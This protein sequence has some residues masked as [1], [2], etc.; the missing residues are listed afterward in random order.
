MVI[1]NIHHTADIAELTEEIA[2]KGHV[3]TGIHNIKHRTTKAPL[4]MFYVNL[5]PQEN[6]KSVYNIQ[7]LQ[8]MKVQVEPPYAKREIVQCLRCQRYGHTKSYCNRQSQCVKYGNNHLTSLIGLVRY[9]LIYFLGFTISS[10]F[11]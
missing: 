2:K 1:R 7:F 4:P 9:N 6:N 8:N 3:V 10:S 11:L 5:K